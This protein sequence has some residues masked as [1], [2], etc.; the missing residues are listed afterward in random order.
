LG[1]HKRIKELESRRAEKRRGLFE[2]QDAVDTRKDSLL[3]EIEARLK[4]GI[5]ETE[6][7][8]IRWRVE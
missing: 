1:L 2:A 3:S 8:S 6:L 5:E 4:Q 7:F